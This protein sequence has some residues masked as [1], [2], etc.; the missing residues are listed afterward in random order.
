[1]SS[2]NNEQK[3]QLLVY[4]IRRLE[5]LEQRVYKRVSNLLTVYTLKVLD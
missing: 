4:N 1:M 3:L 2:K 5:K